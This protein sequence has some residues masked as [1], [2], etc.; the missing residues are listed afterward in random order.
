MTSSSADFDVFACP[1]QGRQLIEASA[2]TGKTW[3]ICGLYLRL[4]LEKGLPVDQILVVTFTNAATA[5]LRERIRSRIVETLAWLKQGGGGGDPFVAALMATLE[6]HA[7][8]QTMTTRLE[9]ALHAF[10]EAAIFT[11]HGFCQRALSDT[12]FAAGL[13]FAL[14]LVENDQEIILQAVQ[15]FWRRRVAS[16]DLAPELADY[17]LARKD[18]PERWARLLKRHLAKPL[19][20]SLGLPPE[21]GLHLDPTII[22]AAFAA[23]QTCWNAGVAET[24]RVALPELKT[25]TPDAIEKARQGWEAYLAGGEALATQVFDKLEL[26]RASVLQS[27]TRSKCQPPVHPFFAAA[28]TLLALVD[29]AMAQLEQARLG[30]LGELFAEAGQALREKKRQQRLISFDDILHNVH[31]ALCGSDGDRLAGTLCARYPAALIDEFQDT[32]PLQF[33]IFDRIFGQNHSLPLQGG[34]QEGDGILFLVGDPKQAIYSFRN[35]D[36]HT[37]LKVREQV[38]ERHTLRHNQRSVVG[39]IE[40]CNALF[41]R[42]AGAFIL[43]GLAYEPV[44]RGE[45]QPRHLVDH[46]EPPDAAALRIWRLPGASSPR[47][48]AGREGNSASIACR[49]RSRS[50][51]QCRPWGAEQGAGERGLLDRSA[52]LQRAAEATAAEVARLLKAGQAGQITLD[53]ENLQPG[54]IAILVRSHGQGRRMREALTVLNV[55]CVELSPQSIF[56][57]T[58]AEGLECVLLAVLEPARTNLLFA[59]LATEAMGYDANR[60]EAL[61]RDEPTLLEIAARFFRYREQWR[62]R[63]IAFMLRQ[64]LFGEGV[65]ARLLARPDG[66]R[67]LTNWLHLAELLQQQAALNPAPDALVRWLAA[68]RSEGEGGE[69]AQL[70]LESDRNLVHIVTIHKSKGLEYEFVFCPFLWDGHPG[71][72]GGLEG[73]EYHDD[74]LQP[75][76]DFRPLDKAGKEEIRRRQNRERDAELMR[77]VYVAL[78]RAVQRCVL[79]AGGYLFRDSE[80]QAS[81]SL[82]NFLV[83][84][85]GMAYEQW[86]EHKTPLSEILTAWQTLAHSAAPHLA[87]SDLPA[88]FGIPLTA[89]IPAG[90]FTAL[91]PPRVIAPGWRSGSFSSL[92]HGAEQEVAAVDHDGR[93]VASVDRSPEGA[94]SDPDDFCAFPRG[95]SAGECVH[96]VFEHIDFADHTGW[97]LAIAAALQQHPQHLPGMRAEASAP[98]LGKM[99][100]RLVEDVLAT[101]LGEGVVLG[102]VTHQDRLS[103][104][105]FRLPAN[106][107]KPQML[108]DWLK[109]CGYAMPRLS[110]RDLNGYLQGYIDLVFRANGRYYLLDWKSNHLG[111]MP[112]AYGSQPVAEEMAAHGYHLQYLLYTLALRRYL[113]LRLPGFDYERDFGGVF[114]L[115]VRG[116]RPGWKTPEGQPTGVYFHRPPEAVMDSLEA[117]VAGKRKKR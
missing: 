66:E 92:S 75:V 115:F 62:Q 37:Y 8:R 117:L 70:R 20:R 57:S 98:R 12:P 71:K 91:P 41:G 89:E 82:L 50:A 90:N 49:P 60:L 36:L 54:D 112:E 33:A 53:G 88:T 101:P 105:A 16:G 22:D 59:A 56:A 28:E 44:L 93:S 13:P 27:R 104:M 64:W 74:A 95:A 29:E 7:D 83:A 63:G 51:M 76:I 39:L 35:A 21:E 94:L 77:L 26:F 1:L 73:A 69:V 108:N 4:L 81:H 11:I 5:E 25:I 19:S 31:A 102:Q 23:A 113:A 67:R 3:N 48:L 100:R 116:V 86:L 96:H 109:K 46:T 18:K 10:D 30:L 14:Q 103:E 47:P 65:V 110:F 68:Q 58:D 99:L 9:A 80:K 61:N 2:G 17:L 114:Y 15:D 52:A 72:S 42:N 24:V 97:K 43:P 45:R 55:G 34:G 106:G 107:L 6:A 78:T 85:G 84:G 87:L 32:D 40:G 38:A 111:N 79:V